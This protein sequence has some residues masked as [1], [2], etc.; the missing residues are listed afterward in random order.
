[1]ISNDRAD[2]LSSVLSKTINSLCGATAVVALTTITLGSISS[3]VYAE[4]IGPL[5]PQQ[6]SIEA[7]KLRT[8]AAQRNFLEPIPDHPNNGDEI[9]FPNYINN[10][11]KGLPHD[12]NGIVNAAAYQSL[13]DALSSGEPTDFEQIMMSEFAELGWMGNFH[14]VEPENFASAL[15]EVGLDATWDDRA[16]NGSTAAWSDKGGTA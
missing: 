1:M 2:M 14:V 13:I 8:D 4:A 7:R 11:T 5:E 6:R 3:P 16:L 10:Y 9:S 12:E 15:E